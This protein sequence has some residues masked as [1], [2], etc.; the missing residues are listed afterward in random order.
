MCVCSCVLACVCV[1]VHVRFLFVCFNMRVKQWLAMLHT[2]RGGRG[3]A[4]LVRRG[5]A[6]ACMCVFACSSLCGVSSSYLFVTYSAYQ[7]GRP[8]ARTVR[9]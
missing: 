9:G 4:V 1:C 2:S 8:R 5:R 7:Q 6:Y 3:L